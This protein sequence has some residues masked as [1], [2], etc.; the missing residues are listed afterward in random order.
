MNII[1]NLCRAHRNKSEKDL[2]FLFVKAL[3]MDGLL[4][5]QFIRAAILF[6]DMKE[7][8]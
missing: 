5:N 1:E 8:T 3:F 7:V 6:G 4:E 2:A